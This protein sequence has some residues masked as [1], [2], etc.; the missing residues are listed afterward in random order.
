MSAAVILLAAALASGQ[1]VEPAATNV[2]IGAVSGE[3]RDMAKIK[4]D[5][6][7][8]DRKEGMIAFKGHVHVEDSDYQMHTDRAYVFLT[9][10]NTLSRIAAIGS[11]ALT[12]GMRRA[13]GEK[14]TYRHD[15][16]LVVLHGGEGAPATVIDETPSGD[17]TL[18]GSK[19]RLWINSE[20]VEVDDA[21]ISAPK[22]GA[23]Q[24]IPG[25]GPKSLVPK[26]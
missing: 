22:A 13:Y 21:D 12:N 26:K 6:T 14:L 23:K 9:A 17:R 15:S 11:V 5:T 20:Q 1:Q 7:Y 10:T 8:Y 16:R 2:A 19:I 24:A 3:V 4:A 18:R 25:L